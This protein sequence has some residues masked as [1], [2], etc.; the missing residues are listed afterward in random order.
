[1]EVSFSRQFISTS[2]KK[3]QD[4]GKI[5]GQNL[6]NGSIIALFGE[7][8]TGKTTLTRGI[9][10]GLGIKNIDFVISPSFVLIREYEGKI[11]LYHIDLYRLKKTS[12]ILSLGIEEYFYGDGVCVIEWA[13]KIKTLLP[14]EKIDIKMFYENLDKRKIKINIFGKKYKPLLL[15]L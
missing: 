4:I 2:V 11:P 3:T 14:D 6:Q 9:A 13:E 5:L 12:D 10:K 15:Y 1:M 7:L 8:G